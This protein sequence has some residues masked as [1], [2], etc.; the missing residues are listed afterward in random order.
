MGLEKNF[1]KQYSLYDGEVLLD[2][3]PE[4]HVYTLADTGEVIPSTTSITK[5]I[6]K[7]ALIRWAV[8]QTTGYLREVLMPN[9][10]YPDSAIRAMLDAAEKAR[11]ETSQEALDVG[12]M[13]HEWLEAYGDAYL[14]ESEE[15]PY[16]PEHPM[17]Q[18]GCN[19]FL[20]WVEKH[21]V[22][23]VATE[24]KVYSRIF[25]Y[26]GTFDLLAY[27]DGKLT[28]VDYK[29]SKRV[30]PEYFLQSSAYVWAYEEEQRYLVEKGVI[31]SYDPI[32]QVMILRVPKDGSKFEAPKSVDMDQH[33]EVFKSCL[34]IYQWQKNLGV[35]QNRLQRSRERLGV[36]RNI[37]VASEYPDTSVETG[38]GF[39][40][41]RARKAHYF[42]EG[43]SLCGKYE[44][45]GEAELIDERH[46]HGA[47]CKACK[48]K[49]SK[50]ENVE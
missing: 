40:T 18:S 22:K 14:A 48:T 45:E 9:R 20:Q 29:T 8:T 13:V 34:G 33:F 25:K 16:V 50:F 38:W 49:Y 41:E 26:S 36:R 32:E 19:A 15:M 35:W 24:R 4:P 6:D 42:Q 11:F 21:D 5:V 2:F 37:L 17:A 31:D 47:N 12:N 1:Q 44:W 43:Q 39:P 27:V 23:F 3:D 10:K 7:P 30:Y 46:E 28:L